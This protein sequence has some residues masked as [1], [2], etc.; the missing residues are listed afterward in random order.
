MS[1]EL[2]TCVCVYAFDIDPGDVDRDRRLIP[3]DPS[4]QPLERSFKSHCQLSLR[5]YTSVCVCL[6]VRARACI[7]VYL[8]LFFSSSIV[9][10]RICIA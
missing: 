1:V 2:S 4:N 10:P 9:L 3:P 5:A 8:G 7:Y 6:C